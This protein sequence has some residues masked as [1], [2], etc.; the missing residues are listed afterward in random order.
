MCFQ[1]HISHKNN[2]PRRLESW[3]KLNYLFISTEHF[4]MVPLIIFA[5]P[6][7]FG[8]LPTY[9]L[10]CPVPNSSQNLQS[11]KCSTAGSEMV[12]WWAQV[13]NWLNI[14]STFKLSSSHL[15]F[16]LPLKQA[17]NGTP[18]EKSS[19][20]PSTLRSSKD[21]WRSLIGTQTSWSTPWPKINPLMPL[22]FA[23]IPSSPLWTLF[24]VSPFSFVLLNKDI[25][26]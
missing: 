6:P 9:R 11:T 23:N 5:N 22:T 20:L 10:Y 12:Y 26:N 16:I 1:V 2:S 24:V 8:Y 15:R 4:V 17:R 19:P 13:N 21:S 25:E 3:A 14:L 18:G 7:I